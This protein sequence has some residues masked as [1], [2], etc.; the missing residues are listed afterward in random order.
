MIETLIG[1]LAF[2]TLISLTIARVMYFSVKKMAL[3]PDLHHAPELAAALTAVLPPQLQQLLQD[4]GFEFT[5]AYTVHNVMLGV[6]CE[7]AAGGPARRFRFLRTATERAFEF[8]T[9]FS[10][11]ASLT[12][13]MSR[14]AF[15]F[16]P[17]HGDFLQAFPRKSFEEVLKLH[18]EGEEYLMTQ[19]RVAVS[20]CK[21]TYAE[22]F[23]NAGMKELALIRSLSVWPIRGIYWY[24]VKRFLLQNTPIWKQ[25]IDRLYHLT[26]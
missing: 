7:Q 13:S 19:C 5:E 11:H 4:K 10:D 2:F 8:V 3:L 23:R 1:L 21:L 18:A 6:W 9:A 12:T 20:P 22:A 24:L 14:T 26:I 25:D 15:L 17:R 16:P